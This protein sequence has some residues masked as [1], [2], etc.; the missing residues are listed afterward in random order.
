MNSEDKKWLS[1]ELRFAEGQTSVDEFLKT[2]ASELVKRDWVSYKRNRWDAPWTFDENR[3]I[4]LPEPFRKENLRLFKT[5]AL[6][7]ILPSSLSMGKVKVVRGATSVDYTTMTLNL[8][9]TNYVIHF[10]L[11]DSKEDVANKILAAVIQV[12]GF[13][14]SYI[15]SDGLTVVIT[16]EH[17]VYDLSAD[18]DYSNETSSEF[19]TL[20][21]TTEGMPTG[22]V[23]VL[24][25]VMESGTIEITLNSINTT[26]PIV[27]GQSSQQ[28]ARAIRDRIISLGDGFV[29]TTVLENVVTIAGTEEVANLSLS[30]DDTKITN[31]QSSVQ[32]GFGTITILSEARSTGAIV[33]KLNGADRVIDIVKGDTPVVIA[34]KIQSVIANLTG[35]T[36]TNAADNTVT[37]AGST[38]VETLSIDTDVVTPPAI[39]T[40]S[41][42]NSALN[43][44]LIEIVTQPTLNQILSV[45]VNGRTFN[46]NLAGGDTTAIVARKIKD[47]IIQDEDFALT[48]YTD[49]RVRV[50]GRVE[51]YAVET[52]SDLAVDKIYTQTAITTGGHFMGRITLIQS[53][54][55]PGSIVVTVNDDNYMISLEA[56]DT[57]ADIAA[58]IGDVLSIVEGYLGTVVENEVVTVL[59]DASVDSLDV[60]AIEITS[61][62]FEI[63][64]SIIR[65]VGDSTSGTMI[66][67]NVLIEVKHDGEEFQRVCFIEEGS[68]TG[69]SR[70]VALLKSRPKGDIVVHTDTILEVE[71]EILQQRGEGMFYK[72][73]KTPISQ[74]QG[75]HKLVVRR[76]TSMSD[77]VVV[78]PD[79]YEVDYFNG[80]LVFNHTN[81]TGELIVAD[82]GVCTGIT[83]E[84]VP[85]SSYRILNDML[86]DVTTDG[87]LKDVDVIVTVN[88]Y[89]DLAYPT[90]LVAITGETER[91]VLKTKIDITSSR[92]K[93]YKKDYYWELR[94]PKGD[95]NAYL[96]GLEC[97]FGTALD[98]SKTTLDNNTASVW[99]R[100]AWYDQRGFARS[101]LTI[102]GWLP[103]HYQMN[104]TQEYLNIF[105]QGSPSVDVAPYDNYLMSHAY[106]G[107]LES[108]EG[109]EDKDIVYNFGMT[110]GGDTS[111]EQGSFPNEWGQRTGT[112]VTDIIMERT[113]DGTPFQ[114]HYPSFHTSPEFM[115]KHFI[116]ESEYTGNYHFSEIVVTHPVQ[117]ERG[118]MQGVLVGDRS[119]IHH[120]DIL[121]SNKDKFNQSGVLL[122]EKG[123][124]FS[125]CGGANTSKEKQWVMLNINSPY[126]MMNNS[127]N[128]FYGVAIRKS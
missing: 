26:V 84:V 67:D 106:V 70:N 16:G 41:V 54:T 109:A 9:G 25:D 52:E 38:T 75:L 126:W 127:P 112:G 95:R 7:E 39:Y 102:D 116:G 119:S 57:P 71:N 2:I 29:N 48:S 122:N 99:S 96:T 66:G 101:G 81:S 76:G 59:G 73:G 123:R 114:A 37:V 87:A 91:I 104:F 14:D 103:V 97:R 21:K 3:E 89:W 62:D 5:L 117:R 74:S 69:D 68:T 60:S 110:V 6:T 46:V 43:V 13:E 17:P 108:Y 31:T 128:V 86:V 33:V 82:Y 49:N 18:T 40:G 65:G 118:K 107:A 79:E 10:E 120:L 35:F 4:E 125:S 94:H 11:G 85:S 58:K 61:T 115:D 47:A 63:Y 105:V 12:E 8:N 121:T 93:T 124:H 15:D 90:S 111:Y 1:G 77:L 98:A 55:E 20:S 78:S 27:A 83:D 113:G 50:S 32:G 72:F 44:G 30:T 34:Q 22:T 64:D 28:V 53:A 100:W 80:T 24:S 88:Y 42:V 23:T 51:V 45:S 36:L 19:I 92:N 56:G